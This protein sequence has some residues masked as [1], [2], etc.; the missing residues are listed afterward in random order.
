MNPLETGFES[1]KSTSLTMPV[2]TRIYN[3]CKIDGYFGRQLIEI[4]QKS[5]GKWTETD[6]GG[7]KTVGFSNK[8]I[9]TENYTEGKKF[10]IMSKPFNFPFKVTDLIYITSSKD[11]YCFLDPPEEI[12]E[13]ISTLSQNQ[14]NL[15]L[16]ENCTDFGDEIKICFE[17]GVDCD[18][19]VDYNSNYVDKNGERMIFIDDSL[20]YAAIFSEP[21]IYEC[22]VKRLM[23]R[24]KQLA[25]LYNDKATFIS[26][27]GCNSNLNLLELINRL[28][29]YED[30]DNLGYVKD[31]VDDIQ[32]KNND[33][34]CKLW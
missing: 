8:Y 11:K 31:S 12:K 9:F 18:V 7:A 21:G 6:I 4:S 22:Q 23:L 20:M 28:N 25:S 5:L 10:Y 3:K 2:D 15:L 16:E 1:V 24:T 13:E 26:Q 27:K 19:F 14:K 32:D 33:L 17:G 34:W 30:S 29:N